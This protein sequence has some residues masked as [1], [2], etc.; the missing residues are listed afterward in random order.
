MK[1]RCPDVTAESR[2]EGSSNAVAAP[3]L[4]PKS[5]QDIFLIRNEL[6]SKVPYTGVSPD[7]FE[8]LFWKC[9]ICGWIM[10][11]NGCN[12]HLCGYMLS[13]L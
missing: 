7:D 1:H 10:T 13:A 3:R 6:V 12:R 5:W 11:N 4:D 9:L 8:G 2:L